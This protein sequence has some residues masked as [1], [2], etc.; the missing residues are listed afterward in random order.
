MGIYIIFVVKINIIFGEKLWISD[1][2]SLNLVKDN[3]T[4]LANVII[5]RRTGLIVPSICV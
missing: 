5:Y 3:I 4:F 1:L 2:K